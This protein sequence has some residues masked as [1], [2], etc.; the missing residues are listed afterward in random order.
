MDRDRTAFGLGRGS[1]GFGHFSDPPLPDVDPRTCRTAWHAAA[2][3]GHGRV[4]DFTEQK[5]PRSFHTATIDDRAGTQVALFHAHFPLVAFVAEQRHW[6]TTEFQD[7]P[8]WATTLDDFGFTILSALLLQAPLTEA[9]T[10]ALS[11]GEWQQIK[12]WQPETVGAVLFNEW[13]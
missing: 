8:A 5:Y 11:A 2:R 6:H 3:A 7:P 10:S 13:D 4:G 1:T 12:Y 9:D